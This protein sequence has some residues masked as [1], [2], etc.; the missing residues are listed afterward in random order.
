MQIS[1][2]RTQKEELLFTLLQQ[3]DT[4]KLLKSSW[5]MELTPMLETSMDGQ[6]SD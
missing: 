4:E 6:L 3:Q 5:Q 2:Q 1:M